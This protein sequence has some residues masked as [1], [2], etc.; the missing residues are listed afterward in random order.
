[1]TLNVLFLDICLHKTYKFLLRSV[2]TRRQ[3]IIISTWDCVHVV[4]LHIQTFQVIKLLDIKTLDLQRVH[5]YIKTLLT[6]QANYIV[7]MTT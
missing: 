3:I 4:L 7:L 2:A 6:K 1:M 5:K